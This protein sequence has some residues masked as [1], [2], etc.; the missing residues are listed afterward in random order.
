ML[1]NLIKKTIAKM[2][3]ISTIGYNINR[4]IC[5]WRY[6]M[7]FIE[8]KNTNKNTVSWKVSHKTRLIVEYYAKYTGYEEDEIV[9]MFLQNLLDNPNYI[10][11]LNNRKSKKKITEII[12]GANRTKEHENIPIE[13]MEDF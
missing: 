11:W 5:L 9:D 3:I 12:L 2:F 1:E 7:D 8:P 6:I 4:N 10:K 13:N